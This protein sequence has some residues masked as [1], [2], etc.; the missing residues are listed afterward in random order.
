MKTIWRI[1]IGSSAH[2]L[3]GIESFAW[4]GRDGHGSGKEWFGFGVYAR[5]RGGVTNHQLPRVAVYVGSRR[6]WASKD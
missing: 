1:R 4:R 3:L 5:R 2:L 6:I